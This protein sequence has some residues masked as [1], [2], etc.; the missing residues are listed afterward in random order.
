MFTIEGILFPD[1]G[2]ALRCIAA[3]LTLTPLIGCAG[4]GV[5]PLEAMDRKVD[6]ERFMGD[7]YVVGFIPVALP[8]FGE[9]G[10]HNGVE[11]YR[12]TDGGVI[13]TTYTF[14]KGAFDGPEK[15]LTPKGWVH[16]TETNAEWRMQF[17]WPFKAAYL[18]AYLD[19]DYQRTIIGVPSRKY[20]WIMS[21]EPELAEAEYQALL[22]RAARLGYDREKV[23]RVPQQWPAE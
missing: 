21:R 1:S 15:R 23:R 6:L 5:P 7:W 3:F 19:E 22:D 14:R 4:N 17:L 11:S 8:F 13:E 9:E 10:A 20:V 2:R 12:L 16:N 18:I